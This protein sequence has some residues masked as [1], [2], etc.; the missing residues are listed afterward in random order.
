MP[1]FFVVAAASTLALT[2]SGCSVFYPNWG[3]TGLP[4]EPFDNSEV[5]DDVNDVE[6][7][8][9]ATSS[10]QPTAEETQAETDVEQPAAPVEQV[11]VD[12]DIVMAVV[13]SEFGVLTVI[14]QVPG[15][16]E[17]IGSCELKFMSGGF[18][19]TMRVR[20]EQSSD[21]TQCFPIEMPLDGL[22]SG[23]ALVTVS[24]ES[25]RFIGRSAATSVVIP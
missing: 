18:E 10:P 8:V 22:P 2:L 19:K 25:E 4:E 14:A 24:Y 16:A 7:E 9:E 17:N 12:V 3:A 21:Y 20:A 15:V 5:V 23:D 11:R 13:E 6:P 1:K